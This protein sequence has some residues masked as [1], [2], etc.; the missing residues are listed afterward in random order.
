M[1]ETEQ[2]LPSSGCFCHSILSQQE[3]KEL[4][5]SVTGFLGAEITEVGR[6]FLDM[7]I[8]PWAGEPQSAERGS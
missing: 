5:Q 1:T 2:T 4:R 6:P 3:K 8:I 7:N